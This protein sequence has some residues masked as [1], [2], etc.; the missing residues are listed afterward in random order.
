MMTAALA[1]PHTDLEKFPSV[2]EMLARRR[3]MDMEEGD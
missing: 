3:Q 1:L 2:A